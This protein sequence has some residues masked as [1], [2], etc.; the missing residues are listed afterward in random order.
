MTR[1]ETS[2]LAE[3]A[4]E[5]FSIE[6]MVHG[7]SVY[8][9]SWDAAIGE[10]LPCK[11]EPGNHKGPFI[12]AVVRYQVCAPCFFYMVVQSTPCVE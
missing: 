3:I 7:Y 12:V 6:A 2:W 5:I 11:K 1:V 10:Q 9:D 4:T 8:Q